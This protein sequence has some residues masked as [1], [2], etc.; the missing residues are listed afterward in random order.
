[1]FNDML[2]AFFQS[3]QGQNAFGVLQQRGYNPAQAQQILG[4]A[5][6]AAA[7]AMARAS[8]GNQQP[9][10]GIF[11]IFG[12]HAGAE[13]LTGAIGGLLRGDGLV[14]SLEDGAMGMV[15]GHI[16]EVL[17]QR[18]GMNQ[19]MAG[20]VA[21]LVTPFIVHYA[22]ERLSGHPAVVQQYGQSPYYR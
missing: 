7:E 14:G 9:A 19:R 1:L 10:L 18:L 3:Q 21:A 2:N 20:E 12:G 22:H 13:F 8:Q 17:A 6:P 16:A 15:G 4:S 11:D 5:V